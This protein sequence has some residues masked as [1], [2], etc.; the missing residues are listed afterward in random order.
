MKSQ[1]RQFPVLTFLTVTFCALAG[2]F[3]LDLWGWP[4]AVVKI[5]PTP[6]EFTN[7][8]T[9]RL[10]VADLFRTEG[11][12]SGLSCYTCHDAKNA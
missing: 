7:T 1:A 8:A 5:P 4:L 6:P 10:S 3:L 2:A 11:D 12:T 9:V